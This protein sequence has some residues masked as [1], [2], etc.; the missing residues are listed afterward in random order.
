M[1]TTKKRKAV[2]KQSNQSEA[3]IPGRCV[4]DTNVLKTAN[5]ATAD[6]DDVGID[7]LACIQGCVEAIQAMRRESVTVVVDEG[8]EILA[9]YRKQLSGSGQPGIGDA[10]FKWVY[11]HYHLLELVP[12]TKV[13]DSYKEF[14]SHQDLACF[15]PPD[16]KFVAVAN[17]PPATATILQATD[18]KWLG[19]KDALQEEGIEVCFLCLDYIQSKYR[20]KME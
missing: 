7:M 8:G 11:D 17:T 1:S 4:V 12:I 14:P 9:E 6:F 10:F 13:G 5:R 2:K 15:D 19:W 18:S 20:K 16:R 3:T